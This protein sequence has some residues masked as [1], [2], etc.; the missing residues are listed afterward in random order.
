MNSKVRER[1]AEL[2]EGNPQ[3]KKAYEAATAPAVAATPAELDAK[4]K[5]VEDVKGRVKALREQLDPL[6]RGTPERKKVADQ[7]R[8]MEERLTALEADVNRLTEY[9]RAGGKML[10]R[11]DA[12]G[13]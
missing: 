9:A 12:P 2:L 4:K 10:L 7:C 6:P 1:Y 5:E 8:Q 13:A 11:R 3:L